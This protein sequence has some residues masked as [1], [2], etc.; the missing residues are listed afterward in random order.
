[1][2]F[3]AR[4]GQFLAL[5][6]LDADTMRMAR[7]VNAILIAMLVFSL[8]LAV[9]APF[10]SPVPL[11][12]LAI[13]GMLILLASS[14]LFLMRWR[15]LAAQRRTH[16]AGVIV[17]LTLWGTVTVASVF[18]GGVHS[19]SFGMYVLIVL[20]TGLL[21][22]W[23]VG[24]VFIGLSAAA[25]LAMVYVETMGVLPAPWIVNTPLAV[26]GGQVVTLVAV[27]ALLYMGPRSIRDALER[28]RQSN[29][30]LEAARASLE[31][32]V[33][34]RTAELA[35][36]A[37]QLEATTIVARDAASVLDAQDLLSRVT[38]SIS[39]QF[40]FYHAGIFMLDPTG[41]WAE[42]RAASSEGG[43]RMLARAHRLRVGE[44]GI[45]GQVVAR[46]GPY[47]SLDVGADAV[48]FD[49]PDLPE[50]RSEMALPLQAR[51]EILG[52][53][54]VQS[55]E[56]A[57]FGEED[58]SLLQ[59]LADQVALAIYNARLFQRVQEGLEAERR[60]FG[61]VAREAWK[62]FLF[63]H[64]DLGTVRDRKGILSAGG[65]WESQMTMALERGE[66]VLEDDDRFLSIPI[67]VRDQL[68]GVVGARKP[69]EAGPWTGREIELMEMLTDQL[70]AALENARL[71]EDS[72]RRAIR[73]QLLGE[74]STRMQREVR[75][76][77]MLQGVVS[78]L[79]KELGVPLAFV[80]LNTG[81]R[82]ERP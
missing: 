54:D 52:A 29:R 10:W 37:R 9:V 65:R 25:G 13:A 41:E 42:L 38:N 82:I 76:D 11:F 20:V 78:D 7:M 35:R 71:Y 5:P 43:Q 18:G 56:A 19:A 23:Q 30:E 62:D 74:I 28:A 63:A 44:Q 4:F 6:E 75:L 51:G 79:A 33:V 53:L 39:E 60:A 57:A 2:T 40:G 55:R 47:I 46:R 48:H 31:S 12:S 8:A 49:N 50:T 15:A 81:S 80:Q 21:L 59:A 64:P 67:K 26:W 17:A 36:R 16:L 34:E 73:E 32:R 77:S 68:I 69:Q 61:E 72:Q 3:W 22:G 1:M 66:T 14:A 70:N 58:V 27:A 45:V 24:L